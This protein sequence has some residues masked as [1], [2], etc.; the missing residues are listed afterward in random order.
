MQL[1]RGERF[2]RLAVSFNGYLANELWNRSRRS[3]KKASIKG[4]AEK[5][6]PRETNFCL[7]RIPFSASCFQ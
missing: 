1:G 2:G 6:I 7:P 5:E 3:A 4:E